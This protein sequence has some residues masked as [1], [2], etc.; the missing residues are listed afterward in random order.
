[1]QDLI[2]C[3]LCVNWK[4]QIFLCFQCTFLHSITY[5]WLL[6]LYCLNKFM[7]Q[8]SYTGGGGVVVTMKLTLSGSMWKGLNWLS[9]GPA[10]SL[11]WFHDEALEFW[12]RQFLHHVNFVY[13][14]H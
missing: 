3:S 9:V 4:L 14:V 11:E 7:M 8:C 2:I 13:S 10:G 6:P 12:N 5:S 1:V